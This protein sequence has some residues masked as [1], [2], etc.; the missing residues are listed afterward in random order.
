MRG[1]SLVVSL[2]ALVLAAVAVVAAL[3]IVFYEAG[4]IFVTAVIRRERR[5]QPRRREH[6]LFSGCDSD[7]VRRLAMG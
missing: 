3:G 7:W 2:V 1:L 6:S 4:V 5:G